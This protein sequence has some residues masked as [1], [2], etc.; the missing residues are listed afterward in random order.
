M[1]AYYRTYCLILHFF[2]LCLRGKYQGIMGVVIVFGFGC[3]PLIGGTLSEKVTWRVSFLAYYTR[4]A[5]LNYKV[6][7]VSG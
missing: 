1:L 5:D 2:L 3:G 6:S 7:G 4:C